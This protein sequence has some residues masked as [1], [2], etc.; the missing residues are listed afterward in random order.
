MWSGSDGAST[1]YLPD[2]TDGADG[3]GEAH[4]VY[5]VYGAHCPDG[6]LESICIYLISI[7]TNA[8]PSPCVCTPQVR[9]TIDS[10]VISHSIIKAELGVLRVR[11]S[12]FDI[13]SDNKSSII[14]I[15]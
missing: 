14:D 2:G 4:G 3:T 5:G 11:F 1:I 12:I 6:A 15:H 8:I 13:G 10:R 9:S 7:V